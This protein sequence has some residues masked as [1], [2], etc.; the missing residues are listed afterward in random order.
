MLMLIL[1]LRRPG[2]QE[3]FNI[4][5]SL[6]NHPQL[7]SEPAFLGGLFSIEINDF[8]GMC[9]AIDNDGLIIGLLYP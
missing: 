9:L 7:L 5:I 3:F 6:N 4:L 8:V 2:N 1:R